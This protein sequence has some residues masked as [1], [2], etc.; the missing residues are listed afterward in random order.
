MKLLT[1]N[2]LIFLK[3]L[4]IKNELKFLYFFL[5]LAVFNNV[6]HFIRKNLLGDRID[7]WDFHVYWCSANKFLSGLNPYGGKIIKECLSQFNFDLY[8]S[9]PPIVLKSLLFLGY[10]EITYAKFIWILIIFLS[11]IAI[12]NYSR[13]T[14]FDKETTLFLYVLIII[15]SFGGLV[16]GAIIAGNISI[17]LYF[18]LSY[19]LFKLSK[20]QL[21]PYYFSI[22]IISI[23]KFPFLIFLSLPTFLYGLKEIKRLIIFFFLVSLIYYLQFIFDNELFLSFINSTKSYKG[24]NFLA[25][26]GTGLGFHGIIDL[27]Q[28]LIFSKKNLGYMNP[29][30]YISLILHLFISLILYASAFFLYKTKKKLDEKQIKLLIS[31]F[32]II[33]LCCFPR[34][35]SYDFFLIIPSLFYIFN[36]SRIKLLSSKWHLVISAIIIMMISIYDARNPAFIISITIFICF[37]LQIK[38]KDPFYLEK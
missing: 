14:F 15:F 18:I 16:W 17:I 33:F 11:L 25:I 38:N 20:K 6:S 2:Y 35:S 7:F 27:F 3:K 19:G 1:N 36:N 8:F 32:V 28:S 24:E 4:I 23:V 21:I 31:F 37:Y 12:I 9:Y 30:S 13:K 26:H 5:L 22:T 34:I 10:F 29:S